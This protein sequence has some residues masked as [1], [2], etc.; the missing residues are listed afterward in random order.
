M[1]FV[2]LVENAGHDGTYGRASATREAGVGSRS[3]IRRSVS[4]CLCCSS[5]FLRLISPICGQM[6]VMGLAF[7]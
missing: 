1:K 4:Q 5:F 2:G 7:I 3:E 6:K